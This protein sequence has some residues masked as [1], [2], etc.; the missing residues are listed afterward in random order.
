MS[1]GGRHLAARVGEETGD[2][3]WTASQQSPHTHGSH[4]E[5]MRRCG[6]VGGT[7]IPSLPR[8]ALAR[9]ES[10]ARFQLTSPV[11]TDPL[12]PFGITAIITALF[13]RARTPV[14]SPELGLALPP[15]RIDRKVVSVA[16]REAA[17]L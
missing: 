11:A 8:L 17:S 15:K 4:G 5:E 14:C 16:R 1:G 12:Q 10:P 13:T 7:K 2:G 3:E 6:E 9:S